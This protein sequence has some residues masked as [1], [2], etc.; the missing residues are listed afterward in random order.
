MSESSPATAEEPSQLPAASHSEMLTDAPDVA[1]RV[2]DAI[3][4]KGGLDPTSPEAA[5]LA[6]GRQ[7]TQAQ[8]NFKGTKTL[9]DKASRMRLSPQSRSLY[10]LLGGVLDETQA[11]LNQTH[12]WGPSLK[13]QAILV[14]QESTDYIN[15]L[16]R[17][18]MVLSAFSKVVQASPA[19]HTRERSSAQII[20]D[21]LHQFVAADLAPEA[22]NK[23]LGDRLLDACREAAESEYVEAIQ[24]FGPIIRGIIPSLGGILL[25]S[26]TLAQVL[27]EVT[28]RQLLREV[29][30]INVDFLNHLIR[31][32]GIYA[33]DALT[34]ELHDIASQ[35]KTCL[36]TLTANLQESAESVKD[37]WVLFEEAQRGF[38][39]NNRSY[40]FAV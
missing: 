18:V 5:C 15:L 39:S 29:V 24:S 38:F 8:N 1:Q 32:L 7:W 9:L 23:T 12:S 31:H 35:Q 2:A 16:V 37:G 30:T 28:S 34:E 26:E 21:N 6:N 20:M 17:A 11:K 33:P 36:L 40:T 22:Q 4:V 27:F 14:A 13:R 19:T 3:L 25:L 10:D